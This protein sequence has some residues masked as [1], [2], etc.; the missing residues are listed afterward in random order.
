MANTLALKKYKHQRLLKANLSHFKPLNISLQPL[1][2][3][4][5][6]VFNQSN[7]HM[8]IIKKIRLQLK[9]S[10]DSIRNERLKMNFLQALP[11]WVASLVTGLFAVLYAKLFAFAEEG[12]HYI[13]NHKAWI[14]LLLAPVC[15]VMAR[16]LVV[17][18]GPKYQ[19]A[20]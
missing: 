18:F 2:Q 19:S 5:P 3:C 7:I 13:F 10:F 1:R 14:F 4:H 9:H 8:A 20:T 17:K 12:S 6:V 15:F 11:F 16:W